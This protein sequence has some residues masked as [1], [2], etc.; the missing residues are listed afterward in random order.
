MNPDPLTVP[1]AI[2]PHLNEDE[3]ARMERIADEAAARAELERAD[4]EQRKA[5]EAYL[6]RLGAAKQ[7]KARRRRLGR[8][9]FSTRRMAVPS[10]R[11]PH[12][13][14]RSQP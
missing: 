12:P 1:A 8:N 14:R 11:N 4:A 13:T 9:G 10:F 2:I 7:I 5:I 6:E 3:L